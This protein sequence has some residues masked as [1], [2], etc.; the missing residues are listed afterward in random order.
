MQA[1]LASDPLL[2]LE[3]DGDVGAAEPVDGLLRITDQEQAALRHRHICPAGRAAV[4]AGGDPDRELDLNRI[5]VLELIQ[6]QP[7]VTLLQAGADG[8]AVHGTAE[9]VTGE[10]EKVVVF[11][12]PLGSPFPRGLKRRGRDP[13][14]QAAQRRCQDTDAQRTREGP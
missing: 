6:R 14:G 2:R 9:Q 8:H 13:V 4:R 10:H 11:Q 7:P 12:L 5:G 3:V 1:E